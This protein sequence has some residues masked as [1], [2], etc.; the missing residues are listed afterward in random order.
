M[1][2]LSEEEH[3]QYVLDAMLEI[4]GPAAEGLYTGT[5]NRK[6]WYQDPLEAGSWASPLAGQH[7]LFIPEYFKTHDGVIF[8]GEHTSYTHAW[9]SSA[10][11]SGIRGG[12]QLLLGES[13]DCFPIV[14][15]DI[16]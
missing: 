13:P 2:S 11:E 7:E 12:V 4:H 3:V 16:F 9:I 6:C 10:L 14:C 5:Y 1:A 15:D 8:V